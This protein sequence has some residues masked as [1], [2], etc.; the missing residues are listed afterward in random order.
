[1]RRLGVVTVARSDYGICRSVLRAVEVDPELELRL[2]VAGAHLSPEFGNSIEDIRSDG[3]DIAHRVDMLRADDSPRGIVQSMARGLEGFSRVFE[4]DPPDILLVVGDR[5]EMHAAALAALPFM[6]PVA[7][8]HGG[9]LTEGAIDDAL[10]HGITKLS[11]LHFVATEEY[12]TRVRQLGE[13]P[14]RVVVSGAPGLDGLGTMSMWPRDKIVAQLGPSLADPPL[15][16]TYHPVT[17]EYDSTE[18]QVSELLAAVDRFE[19]PILFTA[20]NADTAGRE[21]R[22]MVDDF[23]ARRDRAQLIENLGSDGYFGLMAYA[24]AMVG[25]SSSGIIEAPSFGLPVVNVGNRQKGRVR[26][27][28]VIDV[29]CER[30]AIREGIE[31]AL[32]PGF[33]E[34]IGGAGNPYGTGGAAAVIVDAIK[35]LG[36]ERLVPKVFRDLP[37]ETDVPVA[38]HESSRD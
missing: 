11:H 19:D 36:N 13:E 3:F 24:R 1:M 12:A 8:I 4:Q 9:E 21:V 2:I 37:G 30:G 26:S 29:E 35:R 34:S 27:T 22:R 38:S 17:L 28:N 31:R 15:L 25:N 16:V 23:V 14:W 7:H 5:F 10:R 6:I 20:P 18:Q 32:D 33:R